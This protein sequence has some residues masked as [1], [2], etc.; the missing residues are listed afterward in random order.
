MFVVCFPCM[1][2]AAAIGFVG[3]LPLAN[4]ADRFVWST[5]SYYICSKNIYLVYL[6]VGIILYLLIAFFGGSSM[7]LFIIAAIFIL[8][9]YG[10]GFSTV[11]A[12]LKDMFGVFQVGAIH[13]RL[14]TAWSAAGIAGPLIV[15]SV[16]ESQAKAGH[17]GPDLYTLS[18]LI[19]VGLL[20]V[21]LIANILLRAVA[22][23]HTIEKGRTP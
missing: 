21:G 8:S 1:M 9:F 2:P 13:G 6:G 5:T 23:R 7:V 4:R 16:V 11:P 14:L 22:V 17:E 15:N 10:G 19:M 12:Y 20:A 18:M 3:I